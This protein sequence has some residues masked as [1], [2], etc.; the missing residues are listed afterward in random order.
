MRRPAVRVGNFDG[1]RRL[2]LLVENRDLHLDALVSERVRKCRLDAET[3]HDVG[4]ARHDETR[5]F[6]SLSCSG[7]EGGLGSAFVG[8]AACACIEVAGNQ[9]HGNR[10]SGLGGL[11]TVLVDGI[12]G[13]VFA[14]LGFAF[15][16]L[17]DGLVGDMRV[18]K[19]FC[20]RRK[21]T[22]SKLG[23][24]FGI[25]QFDAGN[26]AQTGV[27]DMVAGTGDHGRRSRSAHEKHAREIGTGISRKR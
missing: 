17:R 14:G 21:R 8:C 19:R 5:A 1:Q 9:A 11:L 10:C 13:G 3:R 6:R 26:L 4:S 24:R 16:V 27:A 15:A 7:H 23:S 12:V 20:R 25:A 22:R 2:G 18:R